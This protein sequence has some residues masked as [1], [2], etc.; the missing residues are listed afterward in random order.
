MFVTGGDN[1]SENVFKTQLG[2]RIP[3]GP[4]ALDTFFE[5]DSP[6]TT[7]GEVHHDSSAR[8]RPPITAYNRPLNSRLVHG[9]SM[10]NQPRLAIVHAAFPWTNSD[11]LP[12]FFRSST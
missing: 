5:I 2:I 1:I 9:I 4:P 7:I 11:S 8:I 10:K 6:S 12:L 3:S